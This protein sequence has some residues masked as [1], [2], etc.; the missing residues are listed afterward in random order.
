M[1]IFDRRSLSPKLLM[2][3]LSIVMEPS[4]TDNLNNAPIKDDF[5][6]PVLPTIP[7]YI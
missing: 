2:S 7:I 3:T 1:E 4:L 6:A 5:P